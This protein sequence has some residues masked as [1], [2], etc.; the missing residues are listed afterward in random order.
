MTPTPPL[1]VEHREDCSDPENTTST[2]RSG[3]PFVKCW[4][5]Q[6]FTWA[7]QPPRD[8]AVTPV[9]WPSLVATCERRGVPVLRV[10][11]QGC[12]HIIRSTAQLLAEWEN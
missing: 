9:H 10:D 5:C 8:P 12:T 2:I 3:L 6:R 7:K 11:R 4:S 1:A